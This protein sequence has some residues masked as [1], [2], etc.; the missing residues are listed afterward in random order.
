MNYFGMLVA[1]LQLCAVAESLWRH[2][3]NKAIIFIGFSVGSA[4]VAW[5]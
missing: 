2:D 5:K 3:W 1:G 4:A